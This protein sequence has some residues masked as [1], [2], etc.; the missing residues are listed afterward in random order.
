M[1]GF[2][3]AEQQVKNPPQQQV[4]EEKQN[5]EVQNP[6]QEQGGERQE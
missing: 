2:E 3:K 5:G 1:E 6:A 4:S